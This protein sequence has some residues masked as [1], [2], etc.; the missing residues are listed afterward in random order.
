MS[1]TS[2][3]HASAN[4]T[5]QRED[6]MGSVEI[7]RSSE[8][9]STA[10]AERERAAIESRLAIARKFPR[11][12]MVV[13]QTV[14]NDCKRPAFAK[15]AR[16]SK[17][18]G[19]SR[20]E[21]FSIRFAEAAVRAMRNVLVEQ[22][23]L[24]EDVDRRLV[25]VRITDL[26]GNITYPTKLMIEKTVERKKPQE[27]QRIISQRQNSNGQITYKVEASEDEL[28]NKQAAL[29]SKAMRSCVMRLVPGDIQDEALSQIHKTQSDED[30][31]DPQ[32]AMKSVID[33]FVIHLGIKAQT[34]AEYLGHPIDQ[35][36]PDEIAELRAIG[37]AI[38]EGETKWSEVM[39]AKFPKDD[40]AKEDTA[41]NALK[42]K[43][44]GKKPETKTVA[45]PPPDSTSPMPAEVVARSLATVVAQCEAARTAND[46][47]KARGAMEALTLDFE[48]R[49]KA[50]AA[51]ALAEKRIGL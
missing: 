5:I 48:S 27:G 17:P 49:G 18:I 7:E 10:L 1:E 4:G 24:F 20:V 50:E 16:Y 14:L 47:R 15:A 13:R 21:G 41:A 12:W 37:T 25:E 38:R 6:A 45:T 23:I 28:L 51:I 43:L 42:E 34:L 3:T 9:I 2:L 31:K 29:V 32:A 44:K 36:T 22:D 8:T 46:V 19:G 11:D 26:E 30:A 39:L 33:G 35:M 40:G